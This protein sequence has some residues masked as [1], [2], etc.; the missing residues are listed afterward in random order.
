M[1][2]AHTS[3]KNIGEF[4][5]FLWV[6]VLVVAVYTALR[7]HAFIERH[8]ALATYIESES[9]KIKKLLDKPTTRMR[10]E[11]YDDGWPVSRMDEEDFAPLANPEPNRSPDEFTTRMWAAEYCSYLNGHDRV[12]FL[13]R[14][15]S[16][17]AYMKPELL[18]LVYADED[19]YVRAWSSGH[20]ATEFEH[21]KSAGQPNNLRNYEPALLSDSELIVRAALWSNPKCR[22]LPWEERVN[23]QE[24]WK[25]VFQKLSHLE[26]LG[27]MRNPKL[28]RRLVVALL[29]AR[30]EELTISRGDHAGVLRAAAF[31]PALI[32]LS[33]HF[34]RESRPSFD[35]QDWFE[36]FPEFGRMWE[37]SI[38]KWMD[39]WGVP[40]MFLRYIQT[41]P[42]IKLSTYTALLEVGDKQS[43]ALR[44]EIILSC[45]PRIDGA[46]LSAAASDPDEKC[47][48]TYEERMAAV[49][50]GFSKE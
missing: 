19:V 20:L 24:N 11:W 44:E 40:F 9:K 17:G 37:L 18:D 14:L 12:D 43:A 48:K 47:R 36:P 41:T 25:E 27:L 15:L 31:N 2:E 5:Y 34:G 23:I 42:E 38:S 39:I 10:Y 8:T 32:Q 6:S 1:L 29:E 16:S 50:E 7:M 3:P 30:S 13:R 22:Q 28:P 21:I 26:R 33:R 35:R 49:K 45:E 46:I 4:M